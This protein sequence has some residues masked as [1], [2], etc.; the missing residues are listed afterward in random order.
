VKLN[1]NRPRPRSIGSGPGEEATAA[2]LPSL[3]AEV[4]PRTLSGYRVRSFG[5][6]RALPGGEGGLK[7]RADSDLSIGPV[8]GNTGAHTKEAGMSLTSRAGNPANPRAFPEIIP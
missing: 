1:I 3:E 4:S 6:R 7:S 8:F 5:E 2:L